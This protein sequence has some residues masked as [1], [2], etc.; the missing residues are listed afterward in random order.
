[1]EISGF[2]KSGWRISAGASPRTCK[3][4][5]KAPVCVRWHTDVCRCPSRSSSSNVEL[6]L[7]NAVFSDEGVPPRAQIFSTRMTL[8]LFCQMMMRRRISQA[9]TQPH[10][11]VPYTCAWVGPRELTRPRLQAAATRTHF[12]KSHMTPALPWL[13]NSRRRLLRLG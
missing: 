1:M 11:H 5:W 12:R 7:V 13:W 8:L 2:L 6:T 10:V 4:R 9:H 3:A